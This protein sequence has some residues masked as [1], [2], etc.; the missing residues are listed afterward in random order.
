[1]RQLKDKEDAAH[2]KSTPLPYRSELLNGIF[3]E[4]DFVTAAAE[5][6]R[7]S[8]GTLLDEKFD[9]RCFG[10]IGAAEHLDK[11]MEVFH[12]TVRVING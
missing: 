6:Q 11:E 2:H 12:R 4:D 1:M 7:V 10:I 9:T 5:D 3:H 8:F